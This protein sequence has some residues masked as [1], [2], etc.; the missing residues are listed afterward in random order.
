MIGP[1]AN[2]ARG[3]CYKNMK[4]RLFSTKPS[5]IKSVDAPKG[6]YKGVPMIW[7]MA[8]VDDSLTKK[9]E[10]LRQIA[11]IKKEAGYV[12]AYTYGLSCCV[13]VAIIE[14]DHQR[15]LMAHFQGGLN[16]PCFDRLKA[17]MDEQEFSEKNLEMIVI[18]GTDKQSSLESIIAEGIQILAPYSI[19]KY[20][21]TPSSSNYFVTLA[22]EKGEFP[23]YSLTYKDVTVKTPLLKPFC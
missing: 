13:A 14:K 22:G 10:F 2:E 4:P 16:T 12:G 5:E 15:M 20:Y 17:K 21:I 11:V 19:T 6:E 23:H 3:L 1:P 7:G 18:P 9:H 8:D